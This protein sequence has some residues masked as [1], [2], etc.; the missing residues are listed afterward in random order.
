MTDQP[1]EQAPAKQ[2]RAGRNPD[3]TFPPGVSGNPAGKPKFSI[4]S[5]LR[6]KLQ[7]V[8][9]GEKRSRAQMLADEIIEQALVKKDQGM[10]RDIVD[11]FDGKPKQAL[12]HTGEDGGPI[13]IVT[14]VPEPDA[15][16]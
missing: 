6:E 14:K 10:M 5:I 9:E 15:D 1:T 12:E 13:T 3:G 7:E 4:V 2:A 11:R 16:D 8:P